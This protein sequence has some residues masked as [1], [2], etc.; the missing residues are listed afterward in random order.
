MRRGA[1]SSVPGMEPAVARLTGDGELILEVGSHS[2]GQGHET[3]FAQVANECSA[4]TR[5]K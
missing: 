1:S 3:V 2:H 5:A 4:T